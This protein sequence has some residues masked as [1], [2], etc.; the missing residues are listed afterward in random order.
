MAVLLNTRLLPLAAVALLLAACERSAPAPS[1]NAAATLRTRQPGSLVSAFFGLDDALPQR[2]RL[3][4]AG[5]AGRDGMPVILSRTIDSNTLQREDFLVITRSGA[6]NVPACVTLAP[7]VGAGEARTVLLVGELGSAADPPVT[8]RVVGDILSDNTAPNPVNFRG[9]EA[10]VIALDRGPTLVWG[11][12][13]PRSQWT[14]RR[15]N[16]GTA[17]PAGSVQVVRAVW[18]GGIR[19]PSGDEVGDTERA[20]YRVSVQA[21][22]GS[23]QDVVPFAL[24]DLDDNDN[25]HALCLD[26][27]GTV[28][29]ISFPGGR[30]VD[31]NGDLNPATQV[32]VFRDER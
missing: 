23:T 25:N 8:V 30:V 21:P 22:D 12:V 2:A 14:E 5:A 19:L 24:A 26:V 16:G 32:A 7:A 6:Q 9:A 20:L 29:S 18:A 31:P 4:C 28:L 13:V 17:C 11:E 1:T 27:A 3:L 10:S 15:F